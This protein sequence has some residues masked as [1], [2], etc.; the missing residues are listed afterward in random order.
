MFFAVALAIIILTGVFLR[1]RR[2]YNKSL[3]EQDK[4]RQVLELELEHVKLEREKESILKSNVLLEDDILN[5]SKELANYT[6][7]LTKNH[8]LLGEVR[9][10][11]NEI[12]KDARLDKTKSSIRNLAKKIS[13]SLEAEE[14]LKI[15]DTNFEQVHHEFFNELK[16]KYPDLTQKELRLCGFV[17]MNMTNKEIASV[18]N[19]S[20]RGVETARYRLRKHLSLDHDINFVEFLDQLSSNGESDFENSHGE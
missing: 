12:K 16:A 3:A 10:S 19:I 4:L 9:D 6:L 14:H 2:G 17:K 18:L 15:F 7:Q 13:Q 1:L 11:L 5:K 8:E 20:V